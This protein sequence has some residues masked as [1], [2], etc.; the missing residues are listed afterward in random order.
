MVEPLTLILFVLLAILAFANGSNDVSKG[1]ATLVGSGV[2]N[3]RKAIAWGTMWTVIG[4]ILAILFSMAVVKTF[5]T[6]VLTNA[7]NITRVA[8]MLP[9]SVVLG[10]IVW[11]LFASWTGLPVSTTHTI[12]GALCGAGLTASGWDGILWTSL[13]QKIAIPLAASP[14]MAVGLALMWLR[15]LSAGVCRIGSAIVFVCCPPSLLRSSSSRAAPSIWW[16]CSLE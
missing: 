7:D 9:V 16:P 13:T 3:Y 5:A 4:G 14:V 15:R 2:T 6:G 1:I 12:T 10:A 11:I 8:P